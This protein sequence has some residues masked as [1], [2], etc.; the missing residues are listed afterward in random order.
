ML[1]RNSVPA[2]AATLLLAVLSEAYAEH[3]GSSAELSAPPTAGTDDDWSKEVTV[4]AIAPDG[5]W[6]VAIESNVNR[7]V[8]NA[9]DDFRRKH[10][11]KIGCGSELTLIAGGWSL[12][13]RCGNR[14]IFVAAKSLAQAEQ[15]ATNREAELRQ[16]YAPNMPPCVR[17]MSVDPRGNVVAPDV[18]DLLRILMDR[19][20][21]PAREQ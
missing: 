8:T 6:G 2:A 10:Q 15:A 21:T 19:K 16:L 7:A 4:V 18:A 17:V 5:T 9:I 12:G 20:G 11:R 1:L 14:V 13:K 3:P